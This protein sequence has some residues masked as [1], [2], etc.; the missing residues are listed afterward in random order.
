MRDPTERIFPC[1]FFNVKN[2]ILLPVYC[3]RNLYMAFNFSYRWKRLWG[4]QNKHCNSKNRHFFL[5][6]RKNKCQV[7]DFWNGTYQQFY[8]WKIQEMATILYSDSRKIRP[9]V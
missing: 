2:R 4:L 1:I 6:G 9:M 5:G 8:Y 3:S 7:I